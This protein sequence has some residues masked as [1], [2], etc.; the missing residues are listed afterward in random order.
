MQFGVLRFEAKYFSE[1]K[2][3]SF[4]DVV[5]LRYILID[6]PRFCLPACLLLTLS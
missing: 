5:R 6:Y 1:T 3:V 4:I 2:S